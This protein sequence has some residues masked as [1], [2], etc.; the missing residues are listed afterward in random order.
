M[1]YQLETIPVHDAWASGVPCPLCELMDRA[2][3]RHVAYY[4]GNSVMNP[5]TRILVND[6]GFCRRHFPKLREANHAHH[7][8]LM[9]HTHL[10]TVRK[11][12]RG[13]I[14]ML[15]RSPSGKTASSFAEG[16]EK[17]TGDCLI[18]RSMERDL[19][20][21]TYTAVVLYGQEQDFRSLFKSSRGPCLSHAAELALMAADVLKKNDAKNFLTGLAEH[22]DSALEV[23]EAD[24][25]HFTRKFDAQNDHLEW[26]DA[27]DA[28]ARVV[29]ALSGVKVRL[30]D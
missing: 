29:Q 9:A 28:H 11:K 18:C 22:M 24:I 13:E 5:E 10:Q 2:E 16:V 21:Y 6:T 26:G 15:A 19:K 17:M 14:K 30:E 4:L 8:G 23:L 3:D 25:L 20:R 12:L 1:K 7:L 27:R